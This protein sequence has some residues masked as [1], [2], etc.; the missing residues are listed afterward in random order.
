TFVIAN[1]RFEVLNRLLP[2]LSSA[3]ARR[4]SFDLQELLERFAFDNVCKVVFN[5]DTAQLGDDNE[6]S[7]GRR[8]YRAFDQACNICVERFKAVVPISWKL[9]RM[10]GL[11]LEGQLKENIKIVDEYA[12]RVVKSRRQAAL[13]DDLLSR[14]IAEKEEN[15]SDQFLRDIIV[16]F[17]LAGRD[18]TSATLTWFFWL[19]STRPVVSS[20]I[21]NE[22]HRVRASSG[23]TGIFTLEQ[24]REMN[25]LHAA[26]S[27]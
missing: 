26:L 17:V 20:K 15:Y 4:T 2:F 16:S 5:E 8:F 23:T 14:F 24:V 27:E 25:Y 1:V 12:M 11:G 13:G 22:I 3:A 19:I 18:T 6:H 7:E 9:R 10:F 21:K